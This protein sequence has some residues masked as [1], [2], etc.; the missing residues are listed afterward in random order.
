[1][2]THSDA[3]FSD[4]A[5]S[6]PLDPHLVQAPG[7]PLGVTALAE[8][9]PVGELLRALTRTIKMVRLYPD[10][11][12]VAARALDDL[13]ERFTLAFQQSD[14][15]R[16]VI[17]QN[18]ILFHGEA[19]YE[20]A[21]PEE[22][23]ARIFFRDGL[24]EIA[25][26]IGFD[27]EEVARFVGLF[28]SEHSQGRTDDLVT[29][30]WD[31]EL[32]HLTYMAVDEIIDADTERDA[33][34]DEFDSE[35]MNSL[36]FELDLMEEEDE[37][38]GNAAR[39]ASAAANEIQKNLRR[40]DQANLLTLDPEDVREL[41]REIADES[42]DEL[43]LR[44][45][46]TLLEMLVLEPD[47][48][49]RD[50]ILQTLER[51]LATL[52]AQRQFA[53]AAR[54]LSGVAEVRGREPE[55][56]A[57]L[58]QAL[59]NLA[60][61]AGELAQ[62]DLVSEVLEKGSKTEFEGICAFLDALP[63][64]GLPALL[65]LLRRATSARVQ[66]YLF[67]RLGRVPPA[68]VTEIALALDDTNPAIVIG[69]LQVLARLDARSVVRAIQPLTAHPDPRIRQEA[70]ATLSALGDTGARSALVAALKDPDSRL[71][72]AAARSLGSLGGPGV[73]A[74]LNAVLAR[75]FEQK[76]LDE[77][78]VYF[79]AL[80][81][82]GSPE[83]LPLIRHLVEKKPLFNREKAEEGRICAVEALAR[84]V[85][86]TAQ[87]LLDSLLR[88]PSPRV[89]GA[90]AAARRRGVEQVRLVEESL[91]AD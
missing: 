88:D 10:N 27:R 70:L 1:M 89:R 14:V 72:L 31:A 41:V 46:D 54:I 33:V 81:Q 17:G 6:F 66:N 35:S 82:S 69:L 83:I 36:D 28:R 44:I 75:D 43:A 29:L 13:Q 87:V 63:A 12:P 68:A 49:G 73:N 20:N 16:F 38:T 22:S 91:D 2:T 39:Q 78:R 67:A 7:A 11:N 64:S 30:L 76:S 3:L 5:H 50:T 74:L 19:V 45:A 90:A 86:P 77:R 48:A 59:E 42:P 56:G 57:Q 65:A 84:L 4:D 37:S 8:L 61:A 15:L 79:E 85:H 18:R 21:D 80:G 32:T 47:D 23:L 71:R 9:R 51:A 26:H 40:S 53:V 55:F 25:F 52:V 60:A 34:P 62:M 24:R 58:A